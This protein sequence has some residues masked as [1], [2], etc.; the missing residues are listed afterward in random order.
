MGVGSARGIGKRGLHAG[1]VRGTHA[2]SVCRERRAAETRRFRKPSG[3]KRDIWGFMR[4]VRVTGPFIVYQRGMGK[5]VHPAN[6]HAR[7]RKPIPATRWAP[8]PCH[9]LVEV[10]SCRSRASEGTEDL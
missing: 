8:C 10:S 9:P 2:L 6:T 5:T 4:K 3:S 7:T 1:R